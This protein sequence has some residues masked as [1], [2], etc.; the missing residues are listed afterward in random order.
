[1]STV[2]K[3]AFYAK[4]AADATLLALIGSDELGGPAIFNASMNRVAQGTG[5]SFPAITF[6]EA[7]G[8]NDQRLRSETVDREFYDVEVWAEGES[9]LT[10]GQIAG[11][12]ETLLHNQS[13]TVDSGEVYDCSRV[14]QSPD[15]Y[16][17]KLNLHFG[18]YRYQLV[19]R[20]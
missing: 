7:D 9:A 14:T 4:L 10:V 18:L 12:I 20:R 17:D 2:T 5:W 19:V 3:K 15:M 16:D 13:L 11:R 1:M 6:R 8:A